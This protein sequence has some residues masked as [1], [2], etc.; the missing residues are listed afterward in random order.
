[1]AYMEEKSLKGV[2]RKT[3][4]KEVLEDKGKDERI[5]LEWI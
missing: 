4:K 2:G 5:I 3:L 1:M